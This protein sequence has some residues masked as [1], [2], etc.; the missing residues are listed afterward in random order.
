M[1]K[2]DKSFRSGQE[3]SVSFVVDMLEGFIGEL[4][5]GRAVA[6]VGAGVSQ[7]ANLKSWDQLL[8]GLKEAAKKR[9]EHDDPVTQTYFDERL[10][11]LE[12][13]LEIGDWLQSVLQEG[14]FEATVKGLISLDNNKHA[15][16]PSAVHHYLARLRFSMVLTTNY[17]DLLEMAHRDA[18][19]A[20]EP[21][22]TW[23][24]PQDILNAIKKSEFR[25]V[26]VHGVPDRG[27]S[28]VLAG[29][30]YAAV[31][32]SGDET[33]QRYS[34]LR[35]G[36]VFKWLL[37]TRTFLFLGT[38][39]QDPD[40]IFY[41]Q[42]VGAELGKSAITHYA[43]LPYDEAPQRR[44]DI[45]KRSL[46]V[47]VIPVGNRRVAARSTD[48]RT[49]EL[50]YILRDLSAQ[51]ALQSFELGLPRFPTSDDVG[52]GLD[53]ALQILLE[54]AVRLTG[55]FRG[56]F[57]LPMKPASHGSEVLHYALH[58]AETKEKIKKHPPVPPN[59]VCGIAYYQAT[60]E[61][62]VYVANVDRSGILSPSSRLGHYG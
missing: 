9:L 46:N 23:K 19:I 18:K 39:L 36:E 58:T 38:S 50:T 27:K 17:D 2:A 12:R 28:L 20:F 40:L 7:S 61:Y 8:K 26:H 29:S 60:P 53:S 15:P 11:K 55:S 52:F 30:Q 47:A 32:Y 24:D 43:L 48:W 49:K 33:D 37:K 13:N 31:Q 44:R 5:H 3:D 16:A 6:Y 59:S 57:C 21:T 41:L 1:P 4:T 10:T 56:D 22:L 34:Q 51:V 54:D 42:Q 62:G 35:F 45:L 14:E 25:I